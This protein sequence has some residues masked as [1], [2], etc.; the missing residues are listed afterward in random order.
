[1]ICQPAPWSINNKGRT[2]VNWQIVLYIND[3]DY[4]IQR[5]VLSTVTTL[6]TQMLILVPL[7]H[8]N[9]LQG[10]QAGLTT[11]GYT[12]HWVLES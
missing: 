12:I 11:R 8:P 9:P 7:S 2:E 4:Y 5:S 1:M 6:C 3:H 10:S